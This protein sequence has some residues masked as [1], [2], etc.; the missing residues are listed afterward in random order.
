MV[1]VD[2]IDEAL[3]LIGEFG[4]CQIWVL[5]ILCALMI[6]ATF[7]Y[8]ITYFIAHS[9]PWRCKENSTTCLIKGII[10]SSS[11]ENYSIRCNISRSE[12]EFTEPDDYS[13]V[14]QFNLYC[15]REHLIF[16]ATSLFFVGMAIGAILCGWMSDKYGR[17]R[18]V[19]PCTVSAFLVAFLSS[20][21]PNFWVFGITRLL[22]GFFAPGTTV[23]FFIIASEMVG[24]KFRPLAGIMLWLFFTLSL[25]I[26]GFVAMHVR[27]WK[28]LMIYSTAPYLILLPLLFFI[29]ESLRWLHVTGRLNEV[30]V[31]IKKTAE[32]NRKHIE[33]AIVVM[34]PQVVNHDINP[35]LLFRNLMTALKT[36]NIG[37]AWLVIGLVYYGISLAANDLTGS[38]YRDY[39]LSSLVEFPAAILAI[40]FSMY[41]GRRCSTIVPMFLGGLSCAL[42]SAVEEDNSVQGLTY[43][44]LTLGLVGK[45][46]LTLAYDVIYTWTV[47]LYPTQIRTEAM[48]FVQITSRIGG[49]VSPFIAKGLQKYSK[50]LPFI[51]M[52]M[53]SIISACL[54]CFLPE[55]KSSGTAEVIKDDD[56][57]DYNPVTESDN[58]EQKVKDE[59]EFQ[60]TAMA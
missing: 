12:W 33:E 47:E 59:D 9:P 37:L 2:N 60:L 38:M 4:R 18:I 11:Y 43:A 20:F 28:M 46:L 48:A 53:I 30:N 58:L 41:L 52:G 29:P 42:V 21:S 6:P 3:K 10:K 34:P 5:A 40:V 24:P 14:T 23:M 13:I 15:E 54:L 44:R 27:T 57:L 17:K 50:R 36:M 45:L 55:T 31:L 8:L 26:V 39:I 7:Q 56:K 16:I 1:T 22:L 49:G 25:I 35:L 19:M 51:V 32:V